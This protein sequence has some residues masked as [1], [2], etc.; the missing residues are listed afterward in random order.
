[1]APGKK[2]SKTDARSIRE[3]Q[4]ALVE[5]AITSLSETKNKLA[6]TDKKLGLLESVSLGLYEELDK[7]AKKAGAEEVTDLV[8]EQVND[9]IRE[10]KQLLTDDS[11]V[12]RYNEFVAAGNNP[13]HRDVVVVLRQIRQGLE[14]FAAALRDSRSRVNTLLG[15]A[16]GVKIALL[17]ALRGTDVVSKGNL[18]A[19]EVM[20]SGRW[21]RGYPEYFS[22][23]ALDRTDLSTYFTAE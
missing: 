20:V 17:F 4:L 12:Q 8:L 13:Q 14:R 10:A 11:Y 1:M 9:V 18:E 3:A 16:K 6:A 15:D 21:L 2:T 23:E 19:N 5:N 22:F 7:L